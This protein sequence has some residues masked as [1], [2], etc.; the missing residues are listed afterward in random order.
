MGT[1]TIGAPAFA[2]ALAPTASR[3]RT[4]FVMRVMRFALPVGALAAGATY[5]AYELAIAEEVSLLQARTLA[6]VVLTAIGLFALIINARPLTPGRRVLIGAMG[7]LYGLILL[8]PSWRGFFELETPRLIVVL[9]GIG[10]IGM[11]G[12]L[13][14]SALR[15]VGWLRQVPELLR[16]PFDPA[17]RLAGLRTGMQRVRERASRIGSRASRDR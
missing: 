4:G 15:A 10:I 8:I 2:L 17:G 5:A 16:T 12:G 3:A 14:Y 1:L 6:T 7:G 9:A 13:L 11:T